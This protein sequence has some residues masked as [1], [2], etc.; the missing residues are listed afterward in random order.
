MSEIWVQLGLVIVLVI[1]NAAFAGTELAMVS[2]RE[3]Q[4][5]RLEKR[6][7]TGAVLARLARQPNQFLATIQIGITLAG[8]LA[9][10]AAAVSLA[11]PLE[12]PLGFLGSAAGPASVVVVTLV[13]AY[14]TLV[15]GELAPKR[16]AM[17]KAERWGLLMARPLAFLSKLTRPVVWLLSHSTDIAVRLMGGDPKVQREEVTEEEL[18]DMVAVQPTF[19]AEQRRI[20]DGAFEIAEC[21]LDEIFVPRRD[22]FVI[23]ASC[24]CVEALARLAESGHSRA[25]VGAAASLDQVTGA[26]HLRQ[27]L[28]AGDEPVSTVAMDLPMFPDS[29]KALH[30]LRQMQAGRVQM[31]LVVDE[32][33]GAAGIVTV[34]DLIEELVGEIYDETDPDLATAVHEADGTTVLP[35]RFPIHDLPDIGVELPDGDYTTIAGLVL[36]QLGNIPPPGDEATIDGWRFQVRSMSGRAI[37]EVSLT[38]TTDRPHG[39]S[40][41]GAETDGEPAVEQ[42]HPGR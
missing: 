4:L 9:S 22:V 6:S 38:P 42:P 1:I 3:G 16:V 17:Q 18:R 33:G 26:V 23:D 7:G 27:L 30:A 5:Q 29:A 24:S 21:T 40:P 31:A 39:P 35:G 25:P 8:F 13:L 15:F 11:E 36:D 2:L 12:E 14:F 28:G 19:T 34:E 20:I 41:L 10:A 32:H 37:T